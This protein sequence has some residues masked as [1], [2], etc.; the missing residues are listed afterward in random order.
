MGMPFPLRL[1]NHIQQFLILQQLIHHP[2]PWF[3]K[4][5]YFLGE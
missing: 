2:H 4:L 5:G 1:I 3:P